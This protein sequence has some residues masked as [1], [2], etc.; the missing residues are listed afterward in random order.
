MNIF[1]KEV[2]S[3]IRNRAFISVTERPEPSLNLVAGSNL[4]SVLRLSFCHADKHGSLSAPVTCSPIDT[5][6]RHLNV[7]NLL[8]AALSNAVFHL[9]I[10][11]M[12]QKL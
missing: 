7:K 1:E 9:L 5:Q 2:T 6:S 12:V 10:G 3:M 4:A 8:N 11:N